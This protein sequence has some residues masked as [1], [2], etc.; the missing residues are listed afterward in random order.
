MYQK[1]VRH[2]NCLLSLSSFIPFY[3]FIMDQCTFLIF[4][5]IF[6]ISLQLLPFHFLFGLTLHLF[7]SLPEP[8][9]HF[10]C[11]KLCSSQS[12]SGVPHCLCLNIFSVLHNLFYEA[13]YRNLV[14]SCCLFCSTWDGVRPSRSYN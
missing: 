5:R 2:I 12:V 14:V 9:D 4:I 8:I 13:Y 7:I 10:S 1:I 11:M 6:H 3:L